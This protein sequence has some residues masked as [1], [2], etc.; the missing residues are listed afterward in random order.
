MAPSPVPSAVMQP[1]RTGLQMQMAQVQA[2]AAAAVVAPVPQLCSVRFMFSRL[3]IDPQQQTAT[4]FAAQIQNMAPQRHQQQT[5]Y[6]CNSRQYMPQQPMAQT[7]SAM[8]RTIFPLKSRRISGLP[9]IRS[10]LCQ[11]QL[12]HSCVPAQ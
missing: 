12:F 8:R 7:V 6:A 10:P 5:A 3:C 2:Q 4:G 9:P 1:R 11:G